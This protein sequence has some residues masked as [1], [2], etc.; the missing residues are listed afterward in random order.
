[1]TRERIYAYNHRL[2]DR[3]DREVITLVILTDDDPAWR[4]SGYEYARSGCRA[5]IEFPVVKLLDYATKYEELES[6][7]NPF[8]VLVLAQLKAL[9]TRRLPEKR[10][11]WN[12]RLVK[13]LYER[14]MG[15]E[16]VRQLYRFIDWVLEL[17]EPL[18]QHFWEEIDAYQQ[19]K[20]MPFID[21]AERMATVKGL[22]QGIEVALDV[23]FGAAGL[24]LMPELRQ[25]RDHVLLGKVLAKIKTAASPDDLRRVWARKRRPKAAQ[26]D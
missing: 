16:D 21:I 14:G 25:I 13:G 12:I 22:L 17:P 10:R 18:E 20:V 11:T 2:F 3:H 8:A 6:N 7:P 15:L 24:E 1:M 5:G 23:K 19:E 4:P 26:S 9:E